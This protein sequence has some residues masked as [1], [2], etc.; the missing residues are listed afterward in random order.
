[1]DIGEFQGNQMDFGVLRYNS[2]EHCN[3]S[4]NKKTI[5]NINNCNKI[6]TH[7]SA[8]LFDTSTYKSGE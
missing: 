6:Y 8:I 7:D 1:M 3:I 2:D 5:T 4:L